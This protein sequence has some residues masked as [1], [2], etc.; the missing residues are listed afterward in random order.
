MDL[1]AE[2]QQAYFETFASIEDY[3]VWYNAAKQEYED[4]KD[5]VDIGGDGNVDIG[6]IIGGGG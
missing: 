3:F 5:K 4:K 2:E 6:D 1:T